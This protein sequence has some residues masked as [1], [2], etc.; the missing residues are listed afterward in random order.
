M[1][2]YCINVRHPD[3]LKLT[4]ELA[5]LLVDWAAVNGLNIK[6]I[7]SGFKCYGIKLDGALEDYP[8]DLSSA[9]NEDYTVT[10]LQDRSDIIQLIP[11]SEDARKTVLGKACSVWANKYTE[12]I[13]RSPSII[14]WE[15]EI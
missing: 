8:F 6:L 15:G 12:Q 11:H 7:S 13:D 14:P 10:W 9:V 1:F 4:D 2:D 5:H 3:T